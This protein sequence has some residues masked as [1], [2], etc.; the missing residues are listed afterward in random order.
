MKRIFSTLLFLSI[1]LPVLLGNNA[2]ATYAPNLP[3]IE[4]SINEL[5]PGQSAPDF[6]VSDVDTN[7][8]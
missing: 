4:Q 8:S 7:V 5:Q 1:L 2:I 3:V 6:T